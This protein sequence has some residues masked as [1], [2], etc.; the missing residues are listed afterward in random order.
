LLTPNKNFLKN[1]FTDSK[2]DKTAIEK[3]EQEREHFISQLTPNTNNEYDAKDREKVTEINKNILNEY[4]K[5]L[6]K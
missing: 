1:L 5:Q 2:L 4:I 6:E 3:L